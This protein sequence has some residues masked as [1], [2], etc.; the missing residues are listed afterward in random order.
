MES[1]AKASECRGLRKEIMLRESVLDVKSQLVVESI[2]I[3]EADCSNKKRLGGDRRDCYKNA[4]LT[5]R[6]RELLERKVVEQRHGEDG[7][8]VGPAFSEAGTCRSAR[9]QF[10]SAPV[11]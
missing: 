7:G 2:R 5:V 11:E 10:A 4:R 8:Q 3:I 6:S 1:R 9:P